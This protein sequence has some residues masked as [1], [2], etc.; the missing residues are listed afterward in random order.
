MTTAFRST[1]WY[2]SFAHP[3]DPPVKAAFPTI[4]ALREWLD[5][6]GLFPYA[7]VAQDD[8]MLAPDLWVFWSD[9]TVTVAR[10]ERR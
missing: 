2:T 10:E 7:L 1:V 8:P 4:H 9:G 6:F 3:Q 5:V